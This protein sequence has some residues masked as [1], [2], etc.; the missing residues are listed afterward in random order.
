MALRLAST[1]RVR[2]EATLPDISGMTEA[3]AVAAIRLAR[4]RHAE[5]ESVQ[6]FADDGSHAGCLADFRANY[7]ARRTEV[8]NLVDTR[9]TTLEASR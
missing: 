1:D 9:R 6:V 8:N 7:P 3:Q 2:T 4:A 5:T